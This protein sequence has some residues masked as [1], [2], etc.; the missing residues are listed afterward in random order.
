MQI[1]IKPIY[2]WSVYLT[3]FADERLA[4]ITQTSFHSTTSFMSPFLATV[5]QNLI[6]ANSLL[7]CSHAPQGH[8]PFSSTLSFKLQ[9]NITYV[10]FLYSS[11]NLLLP[12]LRFSILLSYHVDFLHA[13]QSRSSHLHTVIP[14]ANLLVVME[15]I[16]ITI[17]NSRGLDTDP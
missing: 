10:F 4:C 9:L 12:T 14:E 3:A 5:A 13:L 15:I 8:L 7:T 11:S 1:C 16:S 6:I 17:T 2:D